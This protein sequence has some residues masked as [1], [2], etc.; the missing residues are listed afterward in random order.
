MDRL[1]GSGDPELLAVY[2]RR[3]IG[4]T[5]LIRTHFE[6]LMRF[7]LTGSYGASMADQLGNF[8]SALVT[9]KLAPAPLET[10]ETWQAAFQQ[11]IALL[12]QSW[13]GKRTKKREVLFFDELP[14]LAS[15]RSRFLPAF[16]HFW[17]SWASKQTHLLV[18]VCGSAAFW[19]LSKVIRSKG[20]LHNR[21]TR[22]IRLPPFTLT[23]VE[24]YAR[25][26]NGE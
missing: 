19:M 1:V 8:A 15:P 4:K 26:L 22:R 7:E 25:S 21:V 2:G 20:G 3:R 18:V 23:E 16:E 11:L 9:S 13:K 6:S 14:W 17:N 12:E 10:P 24:E 5:F